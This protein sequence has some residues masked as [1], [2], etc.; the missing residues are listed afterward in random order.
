MTL[1]AESIPIESQDQERGTIKT[2]KFPIQKKEFQKW[3]DQAFLASDGYGR[4]EVRVIPMSGERTTLEI[5][6]Q[7]QGGA[8]RLIRREGRYYQSTGI[9]ENQLAAR[10]HMNVVLRKYP[11]LI[12]LVTGCNFRWNEEIEHYEISGVEPGSLGEAQ[13]FQNGDIVIQVDGI[14]MTMENFFAALTAV[15]RTETKVFFLDRGGKGILL[16][17][18]I[19]YL[20]QDLPWFGFQV[21]RNIETG[22]FQVSG[23]VKNSPADQAGLKVGDLLLQEEQTP[24]SGWYEYYGAVSGARMGV[25]RNF[26]VWRDGSQYWLTM[27][28][29]P[30]TG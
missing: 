9:F 27:R 28:T 29:E 11:K 15:E 14:D 21:E 1:I 4:I 17:A 8:T 2:A 25:D 19:F 20:P 18:T 12:Q 13:G 26:L 7:F 22:R 23:V 5:V 16:E 10:I 3:A 30:Q 6:T 24:L